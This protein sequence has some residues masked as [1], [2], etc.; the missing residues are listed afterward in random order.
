MLDDMLKIDLPLLLLIVAL[1]IIAL[2]MLVGSYVLL[3]AGLALI[4]V[5]IVHVF[6]T[7]ALWVSIIMMAALWAATTLA[8]R[9]VFLKTLLKET[10]APDPNDY[11]RRVIPNPAPNSIFASGT[12]TDPPLHEGE[13]EE[14]KTAGGQDAA[15]PGA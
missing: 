4:A 1:A 13:A 9:A 8:L 6:G 11:P 10:R 15:K 3:G 7:P 5:A 14:S 12:D 2:E